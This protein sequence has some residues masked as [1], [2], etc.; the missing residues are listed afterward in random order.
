LNNKRYIIVI[1]IFTLLVVGLGVRYLVFNLNSTPPINNIDLHPNGNGIGD[2]GLYRNEEWGFEFQYPNDWA[3]KESSFKN[4]YSKFNLVLNPTLVKSSNFTILVN[5]VLPEFAEN[6]FKNV[7]NKSDVTIGGVQ[8]VEY[9]YESDGKQETTIVLPL[10]EY[11]MILGIDEEQ[12]AD[13]S[14][15]FLETFKFLDQ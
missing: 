13:V 1:V 3:V 11:M 14:S 15:R 5:V 9:K 2:F 8:G 10:G 4:Y 7:E 12:Y 6:S